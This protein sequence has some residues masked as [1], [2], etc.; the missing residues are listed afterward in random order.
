M[1]KNLYH[2]AKL[3]DGQKRKKK[4]A[5]FVSQNSNGRISV[6]FYR[7]ASFDMYVRGQMRNFQKILKFLD[8]LVYLNQK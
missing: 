1:H 2:A 5:D 3:A 7:L 8:F 6:S 4:L